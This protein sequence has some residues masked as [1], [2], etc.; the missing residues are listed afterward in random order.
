MYFYLKGQ[1]HKIEEKFK[2]RTYIVLTF[3]RKRF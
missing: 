3:P 2:E 1:F